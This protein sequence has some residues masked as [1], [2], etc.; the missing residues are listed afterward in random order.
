MG[1]GLR[2]YLLVLQGYIVSKQRELLLG[3]DVHDMQA[4]ACFGG[5]FHGLGGGTVAGFR[6]AHQRMQ[7]RG[8]QCPTLFYQLLVLLC[9]IPNNLLILA[10]GCDDAGRLFEK[11]FQCRILIHQH[12][13]G[14]G[15]H[16]QFDTANLCGVSSNN[17]F[18]VVVGGTQIEG[19][20]GERFLGRKVELV[21]QKR[22]GGG[23]RNRVGHLHDGGHAAGDGSAAFAGNV[24]L[25]RHTRLAEVHMLVNNARK[26]IF[27]T[28]IDQGGVFCVKNLSFRHDFGNFAIGNQDASRNG[29]AFIDYCDIL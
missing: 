13:A 11:G 10:V 15:T 14:A 25:R 1:T 9:V 21:L 18:N 26:K 4:R 22:L 8:W 7:I 3:G 27:S 23:L 20:V 2:C 24:C 29:F 19:V 5:Q 16:E 28:A 12:I 6:R 17:L